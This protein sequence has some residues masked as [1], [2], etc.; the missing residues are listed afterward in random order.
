MFKKGDFVK[1]T[2]T[3]SFSKKLQEK[4]MSKGYLGKVF[5]IEEIIV[6]ENDEDENRDEYNDF[7]VIYLEGNDLAWYPEDL[8]KF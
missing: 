8:E 4:I 1:V 5:K 3:S 7:I 2:S 6:F